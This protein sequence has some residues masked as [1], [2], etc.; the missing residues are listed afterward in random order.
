M[1]NYS[2]EFGVR[3][4]RVSSLPTIRPR[5]RRGNWYV[6]VDDYGRLASLH[7]KFRGRGQGGVSD[8]YC[9]L[10]ANHPREKA[11]QVECLQDTGYVC[12]TKD[13]WSGPPND[14]YHRCKRKSYIA[15][16]RV[17][18]PRYENCKLTFTFGERVAHCR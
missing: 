7:E 16:Y 8:W 11:K 4:S 17:I 1:P 6:E 3:P 10:D 5:G 2:E 14:R 9:Q 12:M 18:N 15:I 13:E